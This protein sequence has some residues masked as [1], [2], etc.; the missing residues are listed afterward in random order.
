MALSTGAAQEV[1]GVKR[2]VL[3]SAG[4]GRRGGRPGPV[5]PSPAP[6]PRRRL[7]EGGE[8]RAGGSRQAR[9]GRHRVPAP[10]LSAGPRAPPGAHQEEGEGGRGT[11]AARAPAEPLGG[12]RP[13][14]GRPLFQK[15]P[16]RC[17]GEAAWC[18]FTTSL[19]NML[20]NLTNG[21]CGGVAPL[22]C[23]KPLVS[24]FKL[25]PPGLLLGAK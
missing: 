8:H 11:H 1:W 20:H 3:K 12:E 24:L 18:L 5:G 19:N 4:G 15:V 22:G 13:R 23:F 9:A 16:H 2:K 17:C 14:R 7:Q 6:S 21:L 10:L 25:F